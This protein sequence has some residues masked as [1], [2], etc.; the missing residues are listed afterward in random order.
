MVFVLSMPMGAIAQGVF[1]RGISDEA[2]YGYGGTQGLLQNRGIGS[3]GT[4]ANQ[5]FGA[6]HEGYFV[7]QTF[8]QNV[9][10]GSGLLIMLSMGAGYAALS[11]KKNKQSQTKTERRTRK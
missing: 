11:S 8:G 3:T 6:N 2:Y 1:Q 10:L 9:P 5:T 4:F 7:N